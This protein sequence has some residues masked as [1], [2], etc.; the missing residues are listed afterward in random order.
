M[1]T[2]AVEKAQPK[3]I[4]RL[5]A[6]LGADS[7]K[8]QFENALKEN[9]GAFVASI[10][11]LYNSDSYLQQC[12]PAAVIGEC[13]KAAT[14]DLPINKQLGFAWVVPYKVKG[15]M[16]PQFQL[17]Y[18]GYKQLAIRTGQYRYLNDGAVYEGMS[19]ER[20]ALTG[21]T[22]ITGT[23][24]SDKAIGYFAYM[25]LLNGFSQTVY[26]TKEEV[27]A[28]A[29]KY[30]KSYGFDS[31]AWKTDFDSMAVKTV[32]R[33]LISKYGIMSVQMQKAVEYDDEAYEASVQ[34][35]IDSNAN[36]TVIDA[37]FT[38]VDG[39]E[40]NTSTGEVINADDPDNPASNEEQKEE[41]EEPKK[42]PGF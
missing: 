37:E 2:Q 10:I 17:G 23:P 40:V 15:K 34:S 20:D 21:E 16:T 35:E 18:K 24:T 33:R 5:K 31:S 9:S 26:M 3:P 42:G 22:K 32:V 12:E 38:V 39:Q 13:L 28:H 36:K 29:K 27:I 14:L 8:R 25:Q 1:T 7:V 30:S 41:Q 6:M 4:D 11:D 19:V